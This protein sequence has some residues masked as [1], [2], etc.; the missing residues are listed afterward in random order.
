MSVARGNQGAVGE[1]LGDKNYFQKR[2]S[3][4]KLRGEVFTPEWLADAIVARCASQ[5]CGVVVDPACGDGVFLLAVLRARL[6]NPA[7]KHLGARGLYGFDI[8][9]GNVEKA[10]VRLMEALKDAGVES[11]VEVDVGD[12]LGEIEARDGVLG[13]LK[14]RTGAFAAGIDLVIG[15]PPYVEAKRLSKE[16]KA[17]LKRIYPDAGNG[18]VD[19]C[20]YFASAFLGQLSKNGKLAFILPNKLLVARYAD[21]LRRKL[22][23][24]ARLQEVL[25]L[26]HLPVFARTAVYPVVLLAGNTQNPRTSSLICHR[27]PTQDALIAGQT[28]PVEVPHALY[29]GTQTC[30]IFP[31]PLVKSE[32]VLLSRLCQ[33]PRISDVLEFRWTISFHVAG[34]RDRY[35]FD[36]T[37]ESPHAMRFIGGG[38]FAGNAEIQRY[39]TQ[40]AG[41][42]IDY[43]EERARADHNQLPPSS[44][45]Q[46]PKIAICQNALR[47][48]AAWDEQGF[49]LKDTF[50]LGIPKQGEHPLCQHPEAIV[51]LLN[52]DLVHSF[53]SQVF[54][55]GHVGGGYLHFLAPYMEDI[56]LGRW[57]IEQAQAAAGLVRALMVCEDDEQAR[58]L[59]HQ[60]QRIIAEVLL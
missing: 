4:S 16:E 12:A 45:F 41:S 34:L 26:S 10:R 1:A 20:V 32:Q 40:W 42:W 22:V 2:T 14:R 54:H 21:R 11:P 47:L 9:P 38:R 55:G 60:V 23:E 13:Q 5:L 56:P 57:T 6:A 52:A 36:H 17:R 15:N 30:A 58:E 50:I 44:L 28:H 43:D 19:L 53:Y 33:G 29:A 18:P 49:A 3:E 25:F 8:E 27:P 48:R 24:E 7:L 59:D 51:A 46:R 39:R 35:V 31:F 37:P